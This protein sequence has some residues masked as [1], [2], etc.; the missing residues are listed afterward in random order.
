[1]SRLCVV[2]YV[3]SSPFLINLSNFALGAGQQV[4]GETKTFLPI[5]EPDDFIL[6][7]N[8]LELSCVADH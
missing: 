2:S 6:S 8:A 4:A 7:H 3:A 5:V 1:M